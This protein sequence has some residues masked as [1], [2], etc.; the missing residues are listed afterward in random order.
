MTNNDTFELIDGIQ[1]YL[2]LLQFHRNELN[3]DDLRKLRK[4][5]SCVFQIFLS[6][7]HEKGVRLYE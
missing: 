7:Y 1:N 3:K 4:I 6:H 2:D 5:R